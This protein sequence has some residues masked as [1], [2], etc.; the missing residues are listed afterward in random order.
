MF[1]SSELNVC[2]LNSAHHLLAVGTIDGKVE[3]FDPR[4]RQ[5]VGIL[6]CA[7]SIAD[8]SKRFLSEANINLVCYA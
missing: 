1:T 3:C 7:V 2:E 6:D 5:S 8:E 4:S